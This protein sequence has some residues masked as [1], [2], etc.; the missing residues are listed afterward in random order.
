[1]VEEMLRTWGYDPIGVGDGTAAWNLLSTGKPPSIAILDWEMPGMDGSDICRRLRSSATEVPC[2]L[3]LL[4][5]RNR[6]GDIVAGLQS[7]AD[8]YLTKPFDRDELQARVRVAERIIVLQRAL[9]RRLREIEETLSAIQHTFLIGRV[10]QNLQGVRVA[11]RA[12]PF[13]EVSGDFYAFHVFNEHRFDVAIGDVM[14]KGMKPAL[15]GAASVHQLMR[16]L[17]DCRRCSSGRPHPVTDVAKEFIAE[18]MP[19]FAEVDSYLTLC[20]ARFDLR[21]KTMTYVCCGHPW[22]MHRL[23]DGTVRWLDVAN[24]PIGLIEPEEPVEC[25]VPLVSG[26][27]FLFWSDGMMDTL[28]AGNKSFGREG[29]LKTIESLSS[30]DAHASVKALFDASLAFSA[31]RQFTDDATCIAVEIL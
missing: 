30:A 19:R 23:G 17:A 4:T 1:M 14:G 12:V 28:T 27:L 20:Y 3:I 8:D 16:S 2:H 31:T 26:D 18:M 5:S 21:E 10:P 24:G 7:G 9:A 15:L 25:V 22:P 13:G 11:A 6:S 29:V